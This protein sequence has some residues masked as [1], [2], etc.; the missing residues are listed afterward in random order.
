MSGKY[1]PGD[2]IYLNQYGLFITSDFEDLV[3]IIISES[4]SIITPVETV[5]DTFY[6]V[7]DILLDG[8]LF[9]MVPE[10]FMEKYEKHEKNSERVEKIH[11]GE[12]DK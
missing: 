8:E 4:Y 2:L 11:S 12:H 7:Y 1:K 10:E 9:N 6:T 5:M 3:G